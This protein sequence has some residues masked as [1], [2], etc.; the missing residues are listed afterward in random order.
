MCCLAQAIPILAQN[1][2]ADLVLVSSFNTNIEP[3]SSL[4]I[5]KVFLGL[6]VSQEAGELEA[7]LYIPNDQL[8]EIFLQS[9]VGM[10]SRSYER[11]VLQLRLSVGAQIVE[12]FEELQS[13]T[14]ALNNKTNSLS[15]MTYADAREQGLH[16]IQTLWKSQN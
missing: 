14:E 9:I 2:E 1:D 5:R 10:T 3:L 6:R 15:F 12:E 7:F 8:Q 4:D 16:V 13:L 11:K